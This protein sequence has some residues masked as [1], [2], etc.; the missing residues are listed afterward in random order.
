MEGGVDGER[1]GR[2]EMRERERKGREGCREGGV[3]SVIQ[4]TACSLFT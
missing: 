2:E 3:H 4:G 1:G